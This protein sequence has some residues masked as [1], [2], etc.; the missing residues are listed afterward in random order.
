MRSKKSAEAEAGF[1]SWPVILGLS[2]IYHFITSFSIQWLFAGVYPMFRHTP[3]PYKHPKH[4]KSR[5]LMWGK[6]AFK[7]IYRL[8]EPQ[9]FEICFGE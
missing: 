8:L 9:Q 1:G 2:E 5:E 4:T 3:K 7:K 6:Q